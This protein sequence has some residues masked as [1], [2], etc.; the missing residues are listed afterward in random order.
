[1]L[2]AK[3]L[4]IESSLSAKEVKNFLLK[5][6]YIDEV[7]RGIVLSSAT[8]SDISGRYYEKNVYIEEIIH[9]INGLTELERYNF[10]DVS[11]NIDFKLGLITLY[12]GIIKKNNFITSLGMYLDFK[13][14]IIDIKINPI[15]LIEYIKSDIH[16]INLRK[17]LYSNIQIDDNTKISI[18]INSID[19]ASRNSKFQSFIANQIPS[20]LTFEGFYNNNRIS[21]SV[22]SNCSMSISNNFSD[23]L[24]SIIK[25]NISSAMSTK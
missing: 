3:I 21:C 6:E 4:K 12:S 1:M 10:S 7:G 24:F 8:S 22:S 25:S 17:I 5:A 2:R 11:F 13:V 14:S 15:K 19:D 16:Q 23:E 9:P 18:A 20:R